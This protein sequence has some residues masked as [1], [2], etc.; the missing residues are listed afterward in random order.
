MCSIL[1]QVTNNF[2]VVLSVTAIIIWC[3]KLFLPLVTLIS[4]LFKFTTRLFEEI[5]TLTAFGKIR[6]ALITFRAIAQ[7]PWPIACARTVAVCTDTSI[8]FRCCCPFFWTRTISNGPVT[9]KW[10]TCTG[11]FFDESKAVYQ[12]LPPEAVPPFLY[13]HR[14]EAWVEVPYTALIVAQYHCKVG[15]IG[16][17]GGLAAP[18]PS[19]WHAIRRAVDAF[20]VG[21]AASHRQVR[22]VVCVAA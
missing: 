11:S 20:A 2:W 16:G 4:W 10:D 3:L 5:L 15:E 21:V 18:L 14:V 7:V 9:D 12:V 8:V 22:I 6:V 1:E 17:Y 19:T 13:K